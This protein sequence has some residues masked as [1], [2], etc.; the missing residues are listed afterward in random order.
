M[1]V[2]ACVNGPRLPLE[3]PRLAADP[4]VVAAEAREA[5]DA[6]AFAVHVHP[7]DPTGRDSLAPADVA[8]FLRAVRGAVDVPV[9]VTTGAWTGDAAARLA[10]IEGWRDL[11]DFASVNAHEGGAEAVAEALLERG[12]SVEAGI[13]HREGLE[14]WLRWSRRGESDRVL[15]EI[16]DIAGAAEV[17]S[18]ARALVEGARA[19]EPDVPVLLHGEERSTWHAIRLAAAWGVPTR[20]GLEDSLALPDGSIAPGNAALVRAALA[21]G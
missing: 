15:V 3:H 16:Q 9:G 1:R 4:A 2:K 14:R 8:R 6:G 17:E 10:A 12:V 7:K 11:P 5:V 13:W 18:L 20:A 21:H 19:A